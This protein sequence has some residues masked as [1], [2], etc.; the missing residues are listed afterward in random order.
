M[1]PLEG[2]RIL[3]FTQFLS[4]PMSTMILADFGAEVIKIENPPAGDYSR[5]GNVVKNQSSSH[6]ATRNRGKK[7]IVLDMKDREQLQLFFKLVRTADAVVEN[8]KPDRKSV[9]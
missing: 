7:S 4:G 8:F 1:Q 5:Y 6:Y 9:V 3:D 2:M